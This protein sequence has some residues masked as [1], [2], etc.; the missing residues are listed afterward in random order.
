MTPAPPRL[1]EILGD[2]H[3]DLDERWERIE[4]LAPA[5]GATRRALFASF[6]ADLLRHIEVE[7]AQLF[8]RLAQ[9][10]PPQQAL[11]ER[12]IEEHRRIRE[13]LDQIARQIDRDDAPVAELGFEL[14][15]LLGEH[16]T[17]EEESA[18][19]W[20]DA[21]LTAAEVAEVQRRLGK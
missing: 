13:T 9:A 20:L 3:Q 19:P 8:P 15:N 18:Y 4:S 10:E 14:I 21:H 17:R 1:S 12:L 5:T 7:E 11:A 6:R 16:N 2:D